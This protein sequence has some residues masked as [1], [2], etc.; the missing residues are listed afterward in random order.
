MFVTQE[1]NFTH[2]INFWE[3]KPSGSL[4]WI[5]DADTLML[6]EV[7]RQG[8]CDNLTEFMQKNLGCLIFGTCVDPTEASSNFVE[9]VEKVQD[10]VLHI[11]YRS[12]AGK[13]TETKKDGQIIKYKINNSEQLRILIEIWQSID[14]HPAVEKFNI[15][16]R[17]NKGKWPVLVGPDQA[18]AVQ[19]FLQHETGVANFW[20]LLIDQPKLIEEAM[21][22]WQHN[23]QKK[24]Q[25]MQTV[26]SDGWYQAENTSTS[27]ISPEYYEKYSLE[28]MRCFA[29]SARGANARSLVHMCGLLHDLMP[30]I[31]QTKMNGIH[32]LSPPSIGNTPFEYAYD[33]MP[34]DFFALGRFGSLNWIGKTREEILSNLAVILP[35]HIY[36]EHAFVL[37]VTADGAEFS[38]DNLHLLRDCINE[39]ETQG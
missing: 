14:I 28:H 16:R 34:D 4:M 23:L 26:A 8:N 22:V 3:S 25:I 21:S 27:M 18:S 38:L 1:E 12:S 37:L 32:A 29:D 33:V 36:R 2:A 17:Q 9:V 5:L 6:Q 30:L 31:K 11:E 13:L 10:D 20:Y 35:H 7:A 15:I 19:H 24:Y 39:Y